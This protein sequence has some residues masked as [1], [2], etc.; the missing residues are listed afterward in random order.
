MSVVASISCLTWRT[1]AARTLCLLVWMS[2]LI[3]L[4]VR[5]WICQQGTTPVCWLLISRTI[6]NQTTRHLKYWYSE[7]G[8]SCQSTGDLLS[9]L[10][11]T[12]NS[13]NCMKDKSH[14]KVTFKWSR[15]DEGLLLSAFSAPKASHVYR[16]ART[17]IWRC[18]DRHYFWKFQEKHQKFIRFSLKPPSFEPFFEEKREKSTYYWNLIWK[19][20]FPNNRNLNNG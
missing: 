5:F 4:T 9:R 19:T 2:L 12:P 20:F 8:M 7:E 6:S 11:S 10:D 3:R 13:R 17:Y 18:K 15:V 1:S 14:P 16:I